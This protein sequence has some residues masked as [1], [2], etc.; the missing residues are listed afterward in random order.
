MRNYSLLSDHDFELLMADLLRAETGKTWEP[1]ARGADRGVDLRHMQ[2]P[3]SFEVVQCKHMLK[4]TYAHLKA[5]AR[6]EAANLAELNPKPVSYQFITTQSLTLA[7]KSELA[8]I[9]D[10]WIKSPNEIVGAEDLEGMLNR[11]PNVE[12]AHTKLWISSAGQLDAQI[13]SAIWE[14]SKQ[15]QTDLNAALPRY[16]ETNAFSAARARLH[17]E[18]V[19]VICGP[20]GIGKTTLAKLL[21]ADAAND[22]YEPVQ[23]SADI[24][25][26]NSVINPAEKQIFY[27]DDFLGETF[28]DDRLTKNEDKRLASFMRNCASSPGKLFVLT[29]REHVFNQAMSMYRELGRAGAPLHRFILRLTAYSRY[30]RARIFYNHVWHSGQLNAKSRTALATSKNYLKIIDHPNYNPRLIEYITGLA[31]HRLSDA[32]KADYVGF[33]THILDHPDEIWRQAFDHQLDGDCRDILIALASLPPLVSVDDLNESFLAL[34]SARASVPGHGAFRS[35]LGVLD[36][37]FTHSQTRD[38]TV[39]IS[40]ANP[41][42][43]DFVTEWL[44]ENPDAVI[45]ALSGTIFF[46]QLLWFNTRVSE[47]LPPAY[48][49]KFEAILTVQM[50]DLWDSIDPRWRNIHFDNDPRPTYTRGGGEREERLEFLCEAA[51]KSAHLNKQ[52]QNLFEQK[53]AGIRASWT[54]RI[55]DPSR[56]V[57]LVR[58]LEKYD[59][60]DKATFDAAADALEST[61]AWLYL[62]DQLNDLDIFRPTWFGDARRDRMRDAFKAWVDETL[63]YPDEIQDE[64]ELYRLE[65]LASS[66]GVDVDQGLLDSAKEDISSRPVNYMEEEYDDDTDYSGNP[67]DESQAISALFARLHEM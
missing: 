57:R 4:S 26:G 12:R 37:S 60:L 41:S 44:D 9:L 52:T 22:G 49:P 32:D 50:R 7:N 58:A 45:D 30:E 62:W 63:E 8:R 25:E 20:P 6:K 13:N 1:F 3:L 46:E 11:H 65:T 67:V 47:N 21:V 10:G 35:A 14:R 39:F 5:Q 2:S 53:L 43:R 36:D 48:A 56:P 34:S 15:L 42:I 54:G 40:F 17:S 28:L 55:S 19:L 23:V 38:G 64:D 33:S 27:Y 24:D 16:V 18:R 31:S 59:R 66:I 51:S 29:T 61:H